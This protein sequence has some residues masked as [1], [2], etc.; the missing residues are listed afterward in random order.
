MKYRALLVSLAIVLLLTLWMT[1]ISD[2]RAQDDTPP[3]PTPASLEVVNEYFSTYTTATREGESITAGFINGP[4][5]PPD[6]GQRI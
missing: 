1:P 3:Q 4:S 6:H 2:V 5:E